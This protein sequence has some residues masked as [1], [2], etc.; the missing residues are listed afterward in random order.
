MTITLTAFFTI[1]I[2]LSVSSAG[3]ILQKKEMLSQNCIPGFSTV[4]LYICQPCLTVYT[5]YEADITL[6]NV[7]NMLVFAGLLLFVFLLVLGGAFL[8]LRK[9]Y[10]RAIYRILTIATMFSNCAF[11]GI[12]IIEALLPDYASEIIIYTTVFG[13]MMNIIGWTV[14]SAI[15]ANNIK[16]MSVK[17]ILLNPATLG[18]VAAVVILVLNIP[19][20]S[21]LVSIITVTGKMCT[22]LSMLII[23]MRLATIEFKKIFTDYRIYITIA[24][25][26]IVVPLLAFLIVFSLDMIDV[27][28][29]K[30]LFITCACPSASVVLNYSEIVGEGQKEA[31]NLVLLST[32]S[33]CITLP[34]IMLL[35]PFI[36]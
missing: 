27:N 1:L 30:T 13:L 32:I 11:F 28:L 14:G 7:K 16:F 8:I 25:K 17:K 5:F 15:I 19:L 20:S 36:A 12:P 35:L 18:A 26:Q 22:P 6:E 24:I 4:L 23:G 10:D 29:R 3:F 21:S 31:A 33:C 9:K 34:L 2:L